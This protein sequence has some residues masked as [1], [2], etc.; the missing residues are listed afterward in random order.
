MRGHYLKAASHSWVPTMRVSESDAHSREWFWRKS[1][2]EKTQPQIGCMDV[3]GEDLSLTEERLIAF[4]FHSQQSNHLQCMS[5]E[6]QGTLQHLDSGNHGNPF[7]LGQGPKPRWE[8]PCSLARQH[9]PWRWKSRDAL[10]PVYQLLPSCLWHHTLLQVS[11][12]LGFLIVPECVLFLGT[13][14]CWVLWVG[15]DLPTWAHQHHFLLVLEERFLWEVSTLLKTNWNLKQPP[16]GL[17]DILVLCAITRTL[18]KD[19]M[20]R[21]KLDGSNILFPFLLFLVCKY[22][23]LGVLARMWRGLPC[24]HALHC[25]PF[26]F[27]NKLFLVMKHLVNISQGST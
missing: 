15:L 6:A 5:Q 19:S 17:M 4:F 12:P 8:Q 18:W 20:F 10:R 26:F 16:S 13:G 23:H 7:H 22:S 25:N 2:S 21:G 14:P 24:L 1:R 11:S 9:H 27:S 3:C